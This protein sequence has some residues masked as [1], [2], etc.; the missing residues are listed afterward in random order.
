M[1][2]YFCDLCQE[3]VP[4]DHVARGLASVRG[5]RVV[6]R[7]CNA[8]MAGKGGSKGSG[9]SAGEAA[10][11]SATAQKPRRQRVVTPGVAAA[12]ALASVGLALCTSVLLLLRVE[13]VSGEWSRDFESAGAKLERIEQRQLGTREFMVAEARA[14]SEEALGGERERL[15]TMQRQLDELRAA[16]MPDEARTGPESEASL[17]EVRS[18]LLTPGDGLERVRELEDQ[19]LFL[20]AR[21]LELSE[22]RELRAVTPEPD[23][24]R[25]LPVPTSV[26]ELV[27]RLHDPDPV[28]RVGALYALAKVSDLGVVSH[29]SPLL[30]DEDAYIRALAARTLERL[31][32][33]AAV[34][35]LLEAL[36]DG[37]VLVREAAIS[38]LRSITGHQSLYDPR[39]T[40]EERQAAVE[41]WR[42]WWRDHW[43][44]FLYDEGAT[45]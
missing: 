36:G 16:L 2:L 23:A 19:L 37:D 34:Q 22:D 20:Q 27:G 26:P 38:A 25:P 1:E 30:D 12:L 43:Q 32:A 5:E 11:H 31:E 35:P 45:R 24:P 4:Q 9:E 8:A 3:A 7:S 29:V 15:A 28:E 10:N 13:M 6:C 42:A 39:G 17:E 33:R 41:R 44:A 18:E 21:V 40:F 14:V